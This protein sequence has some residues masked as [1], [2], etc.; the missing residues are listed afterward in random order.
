MGKEGGYRDGSCPDFEYVTFIEK[1]ATDVAEKTKAEHEH[2]S[3]YP[4]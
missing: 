1:D 3:S 4:A 2:F